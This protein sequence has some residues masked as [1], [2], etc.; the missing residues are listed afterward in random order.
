MKTHSSQSCQHCSGLYPAVLHHG[1]ALC[2]HM[3]CLPE[4]SLRW[5]TQLI[6]KHQKNMCRSPPFHSAQWYCGWFYKYTA[7]EGLAKSGEVTQTH[8]ICCVLLYSCAVIPGWAAAQ[9]ALLGMHM[10]CLTLQQSY[11]SYTVHLSALRKF[12]PSLGIPC[13]IG[14]KRRLT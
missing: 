6:W 12:I 9:R 2:S 10:D 11:Y 4:K 7:G 14:S 1:S 3:P 5:G 13:C 8:S